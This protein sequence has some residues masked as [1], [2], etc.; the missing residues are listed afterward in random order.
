MRKRRA[1]PPLARLFMWLSFP[2]ARSQCF[3]PF[4]QQAALILVCQVANVVTAFQ[5]KTFLVSSDMIQYLEKDEELANGNFP[6]LLRRYF[7][8]AAVCDCQLKR[9]CDLACIVSQG[10]YITVFFRKACHSGQDCRASPDL[11]LES[12][13]LNS[14]EIHNTATP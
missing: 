2:I 10:I 7:V 5:S 14:F 4:V 12:A 3:L 6:D 1:G 8:A 11:H 13:I 9:L